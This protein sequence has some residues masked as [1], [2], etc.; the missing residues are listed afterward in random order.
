ME[1]MA[2]YLDLVRTAEAIIDAWRDKFATDVPPDLETV[3]F[4]LETTPPEVVLRAIEHAYASRAPNTY[5]LADLV[6]AVDDYIA[7]PEPP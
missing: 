5:L 1:T 6:R 7:G 3:R 2:D 4:W